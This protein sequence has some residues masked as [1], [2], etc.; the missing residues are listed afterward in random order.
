MKSNLTKKLALNRVA[1]LMLHPEKIN[2]RDKTA[3]KEIE[4][5]FTSIKQT[6]AYCEGTPCGE[7]PA[8]GNNNLGDFY[9]FMKSEQRKDYN[10]VIDR[11]IRILDEIPTT[12]QEERKDFAMFLVR[13][14]GSIPKDELYNDGE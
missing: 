1:M 14:A 10:Y 13:Y 8:E 9:K 6:K 7:I 12:P 3:I 11:S 4:E 5:Y 2:E